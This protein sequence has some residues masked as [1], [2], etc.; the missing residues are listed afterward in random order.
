MTRRVQHNDHVQSTLQNDTLPHPLKSFAGIEKM[1]VIMM[2]PK[3]ARLDPD[4]ASIQGKPRPR[5]HHL[6]TC[7]EKHACTHRDTQDKA[8]QKMR[9]HSHQGHA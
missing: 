2:V 9:L 4:Y 1:I 5:P 7:A 8:L 3:I 6:L